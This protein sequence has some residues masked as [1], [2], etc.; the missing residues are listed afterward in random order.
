M[1]ITITISTDNA[2]FSPEPEDEVARILRELATKLE[3]MRLGGFT[4]RDA[5]GNPVGKM[6]FT[7]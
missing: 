5:N 2:A 3:T 4:L 7:D 1:N 6:E